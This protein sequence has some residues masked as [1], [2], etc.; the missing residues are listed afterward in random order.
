MNI[1]NKAGIGEITYITSAS[2]GVFS[3]FSDEFQT[4][5]DAG[6]DIIYVCDGCKI[7]VNNEIISD[8]KSCKIA[9]HPI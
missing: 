7:A 6:E 3:Q 8:N 1:F 2:G 9:I 4:V 5:T